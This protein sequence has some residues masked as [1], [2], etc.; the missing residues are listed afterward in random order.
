[1]KKYK[2]T[3]TRKIG[4]REKR[5]PSSLLERRKSREGE[6]ESTHRTKKSQKK[7]VPHSKYHSGGKK[8]KGGQKNARRDYEGTISGIRS[9]PQCASNK[10]GRNKRSELT[11]KK[12][13]S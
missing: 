10:G 11:G 13:K 3:Y 7:D 4:R 12:K 2:T 5:R 9:S 6:V 1:M 8:T